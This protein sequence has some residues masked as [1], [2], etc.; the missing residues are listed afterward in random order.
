MKVL[1]S[2][3]LLGAKVKYDGGDN[4]IYHDRLCELDLVPC[5]PEVDGGLP[6]PRVPAEIVG[7]KVFNQEGK[8]V[9]EAFEKGATQALFLVKEHGIQVALLKAKSPSCG[10]DMIYDG[11]FTKSLKKGKGMT[12]KML[13]QAGVKVFNETQLEEMFA[14]ITTLL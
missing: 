2:A 4:R 10:N 1:I 3:C 5:C 14:Y 8:E 7:E 6:I 12:A 11:T 9:T 13:E